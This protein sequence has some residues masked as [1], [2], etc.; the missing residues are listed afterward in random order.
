MRVFLVFP[1]LSESKYRAL[2][3]LGGVDILV[4]YTTL[5]WKPGIRGRLAML[6][7]EDLLTGVMLDSGAYHHGNGYTRVDPVEYSGFA[8]SH[9]SLFDY[10][11]APDVPGRQV[12]SLERTMAMMEWYPG[13]FIPVLQPPGGPPD[14][15][16]HAGYIEDLERIG[17]LDRAPRVEGGGVLV[18]LGG[19]D[20][21]LRRIGYIAEVVRLIEREYPW[22]RLHIF[23]AGARVLKGLRRRGLIGNVYS[24]DSSSW[25]SEIMWRR[26]TVYNAGDVVEANIAAINGYLERIHS[27]LSA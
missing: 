20:G 15:S 3:A 17:A 19:L 23:G 11:V 8:S 27:A 13:E 4:S 10:I 12:E 9:R 26:R 24:V 1:D 22:A 14:P 5:K 21:G 18:G 6:R 16:A 2:R 25:L 7:G